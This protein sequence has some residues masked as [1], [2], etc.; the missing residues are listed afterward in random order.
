MNYLITGGTGFIGR[1]L[2][3]DLY[4]NGDFIKVLSRSDGVSIDNCEVVQSLD[5]IK[6]DDSIDIIINLAGRPVDHL[7]T[8]SIK[9]DLIESRVNITN[10]LLKLIQ[11]LNS[12][13]KV[14][15]SASAIGYYGPYNG[16]VLDEN[17]EPRSS[18]TNSLC[19]SW[20]KEACKATEEGVRVCITR[21]GIVLG[22]DGGFIKKVFVPFSLGLGGKVGDG[23]QIFSWIHIKDVINGI[24][25]LIQCDQCSGKYNFVSPDVVT[26]EEFMKCIGKVLNRPVLL[27]IP[28]MFLKLA[29]GEMAEELLLTGNEVKPQKLLSEG[30][31]FLY[32]NHEDALLDILKS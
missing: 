32:E 27:S 23:S 31:K 5:E 9:K 16:A 13:P 1:N 6:D 21:F 22:R 2:I 12:K 24:K 4:K 11:R 8:D 30:Y 10:S 3:S 19:D 14:M 28:D 25:F 18:F 26:N 29:L 20:E 17:S 7:W 15:I